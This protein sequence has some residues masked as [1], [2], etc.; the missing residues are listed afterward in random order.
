[1]QHLKNLLQQ[2]TYALL[3]VL[4]IVIPRAIVLQKATRVG[5]GVDDLQSAIHAFLPIPQLLESVRTF[6]PHPPL[7]YLQLHFWEWAGT[8]DA[9]LRANTILWGVLSIASLLFVGKKVWG[10][11][12]IG[13]LSSMFF[14]LSPLLLEY[15]LSLRMYVLMIFLGIWVWYFTHIFFTSERLYP[16]GFGVWLSALAFLYSQGAAFIILPAMSAYALLLA[17]KSWKMMWRRL[18][19][20]LAI[21]GAI[22]ILYIPWLLRA[23]D[24]HLAHPLVPNWKDVAMT[25]SQLLFGHSIV[26]ISG[27]WGY[28]FPTVL[29][30]LLVVTFLWNKRSKDITIA[31]ILVPL[32]TCF[33]VSYL[34]EPIWLTRT[35]VLVS[36]FVSLAVALVTDDILRNRRHCGGRNRFHLWGK[37]SLISVFAA[38]SFFAIVSFVGH[39][40]VT[41]TPLK[42]SAIYIHE[43]AGNNDIVFIPNER[44]YW[45]WCWYFLGPG[46]VTPLTTDYTMMQDGITIISRPSVEAQTRQYE[47]ERTWWIVYRDYDTFGP[48]PI[49]PVLENPE[50]IKM[51]FNTCVA[52]VVIS[53][54]ILTP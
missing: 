34:I 51:F 23:K 26:H 33:L 46:H 12:Q 37:I 7:F 14:A 42:E 19:G 15:S 25:I 50:T 8:G 53:K 5:L 10:S 45:G 2:H 35:L 48:L 6:D 31:F 24:I 49:E 54:D 13:I 41:W 18:V 21:Q 44:M 39:N 36:P 32:A 38:G 40:Y 11:A 27:R 28:V 22:V 17:A 43:N 9:W 52:K 29:F 1:M 47:G 20:Y 4:F 30:I 16:A 3:L